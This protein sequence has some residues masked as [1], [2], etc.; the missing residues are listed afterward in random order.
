MDNLTSGHTRVRRVEIRW[1]KNHSSQ[2]RS[3]R[4]GAVRATT[5]TSNIATQRDAQESQNA[6]VSAAM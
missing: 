2:A 3:F 5:L 6:E 4:L 1:D